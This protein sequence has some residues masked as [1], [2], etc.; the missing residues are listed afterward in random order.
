MTGG[1]KFMEHHSH[2]KAAISSLKRVM[3]PSTL[4]VDRLAL[5]L[6]L[7]HTCNTQGSH[8]IISHEPARML[9]SIS[10]DWYSYIIIQNVQRK[11]AQGKENV[12]FQSLPLVHLQQECS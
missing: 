8:V 7:T 3:M 10:E 5:S 6:T 11:M 1:K 4:I 9:A 12:H 2:L